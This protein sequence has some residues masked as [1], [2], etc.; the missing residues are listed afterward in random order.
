M[1]SRPRSSPPAR[2]KL[3]QILLKHPFQPRDVAIICGTHVT[4]EAGTGLVHTAPAHG[5]DDYNIGKKYGLPVNNPVAN[6]GR[7]IST[8]PALSV[9]ELAGKTVW[10]AN[11]LVLQELESRGRLLNNEKI[12]HSYPH[13]WRHKT[14]I[15]F[16]AT[17]QWF[18]GMDHQAKMPRP[19]AG[20]PSAPLMKPSSF[21][22]G[23]A[24]GW[25]R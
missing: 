3:D 11:P 14:P 1:A 6:D 22:P 18:I 21:R 5:V 25:K 12:K 8:T 7:F 23:A 4:T 16:R 19:C 2:A 15:I 20:S 17:T 13:C 10:E 9:G 24:P